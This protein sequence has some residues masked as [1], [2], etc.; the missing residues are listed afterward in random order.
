MKS[1]KI[2]PVAILH[3][4]DPCD[5]AKAIELFWKRRKTAV[6]KKREL[7][8]IESIIQGII[9]N[10]GRVHVGFGQVIDQDFETPEALAEEIDRQIH[11][12]YKLFPVNLLA[13]E[14]DDESISRSRYERVWR[15]LSGLPKGA[16]QYLIDSY[17][18][19]VKKHWLVQALGW[20]V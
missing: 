11:D 9:G 4:N 14:K 6:T 17:A 16:R 12:N 18:N 13:A 5:T 20:C 10:K 7:E 19:P 8:D 3:E 2:A 15:K 1:L